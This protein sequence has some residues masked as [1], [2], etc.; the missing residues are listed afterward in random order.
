LG[1]CPAIEDGRMATGN[2]GLITRLAHDCE[3]KSRVRC[4]GIWACAALIVISAAIQYLAW[5]DKGA[6]FD[7]P[8]H[9][10]AAYVQTA[11]GDFRIDPE[12]PP[13]WKYYVGLGMGKIQIDRANPLWDESLGSR[14]AEG[15]L[16]RET[17]YG[18]GNNT[19]QLVD[20]ARFR[21]TLVGCA[22]AVVTGWWARRLAG[23]V[24]AVVAVAALCFDP[25]F[26]AHAP[27]VKNDVAMALCL[28]LLMAGVWLMGEKA[29]AARCAAVI[30]LGAAAIN[31]KFS[32]VI[33][34]PLAG[35]ALAVRALTNRPWEWLGRPVA[36]RVGRCVCVLGLLIAMAVV[37][38]A[39]IWACYQFRFS[40]TRDQQHFGLADILVTQ[41]KGDWIA[42]HGGVA[43]PVANEMD[44]VVAQWQPTL[45]TRTII[46]ALKHRLFP[47]AF[48]V[49]ALH[50]SA[51]SKTRVM[52]LAGSYSYRGW[53]WYFPLAWA[54]KTPITVIAALGLALGYYLWRRAEFRGLDRRGIFVTIFSAALY[55][56]VAAVSGVDVGIRHL[57]P[58]YPYLCVLLGVAAAVAIRSF[59]KSTGAVLAAF[60]LGIAAE[61]AIA[62]PNFIPFIDEAFGGWRRGAD[63]LSD[64]NVDWGEDLPALAAWQRENAG[65]SLQLCYFGSADPRYYGIHYVNLPGS[66]APDDEENAGERPGAIAVSA[67]MLDDPLLP[68]QVRELLNRLRQTT[69]IAVLGHTIYV[70]AA[71]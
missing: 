8:T 42:E 66:M 19:D 56:A 18:Q 69:P 22:L 58:V 47:E 1:D 15:T 68:P 43:P 37:S 33:A 16:V 44:A 34:F 24:A 61:A 27:L 40:P 4:W 25:N 65:Y 12:N 2:R 55:F 35:A 64:S 28:M 48:L 32:G 52:F 50:L 46:A 36:S 29:K 14:A 3:T 13:L 45:A 17:I 21:M 71:P 53:W 67:G 5:R 57:L 10:L 49:G 23:D 59:P 20:A 70:H 31:V 30:M 63:L 54:V 7:E 38:W 11:E 62:F 26:L 39:A 6:T 41:A 60:L 9:L 51:L